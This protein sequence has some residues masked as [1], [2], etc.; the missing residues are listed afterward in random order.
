[1]GRLGNQLFQI[2]S[3]LGYARK[4]KQSVEFPKWSYKNDFN[5]NFEPS[6]EF[7]NTVI[8]ELDI[9]NYT[10]LPKYDPR[11]L[12]VSL[13]GYLQSEK[14][15]EN[16]KAEIFN[17]FKTESTDLNSGFVHLRF[18]DYVGK[19]E[20]HPLQSK[21]YYVEGMKL[22]NFDHYYCFSD[23]IESCKEMFKED[24]R[25]EF[26]S[27]NSEIQDLKLMSRCKGAVIANSSFSWW[28]A[29]LGNH[30]N[31][32]IPKTWFGPAYNWFKIEDRLCEGWR[33]I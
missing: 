28:G 13:N 3:T 15:F 5:F 12:N 7:I 25:I 22:L 33:A 31:V 30:K 16:V 9:L 18:G 27:G 29:Y 14:Y 23:D 20:Y 32:I 21:E 8:S 17:I 6:F 4:Y 26:V 10:E 19:Q 24:S 11:M 1:M 2:A